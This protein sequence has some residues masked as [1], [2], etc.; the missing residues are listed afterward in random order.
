MESISLWYQKIAWIDLHIHKLKMNVPRLKLSLVNN[1]AIILIII[2]TQQVRA[3]FVLWKSS[4]WH[5]KLYIKQHLKY[6][7]RLPLRKHILNKPHQA[8][9]II[10]F[11]FELNYHFLNWDWRQLYIRRYLMTQRPFL[12]SKVNHS[13]SVCNALFIGWSIPLH[14]PFNRLLLELNNSDKY[15][16]EFIISNC[17]S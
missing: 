12:F 14:W 16:F 13:I 17:Y 8:W 11:S 10:S 15:T 5:K 4:Q 9:W 1:S 7:Q 2:F 6:A 3:K